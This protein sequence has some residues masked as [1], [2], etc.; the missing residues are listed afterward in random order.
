MRFSQP[1]LNRIV[2]MI[3]KNWKANNVVIFKAD[4][5]AVVESAMKAL[6]KELQ[7]EADL[8]KEVQKMLDNLEK[9]NSGE[10]QR[11]KMAGLLKQK[12]AKEKKVVL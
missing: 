7:K 6:N 8:D 12:L 2:E 10:F 1:Q 3:L 5:K 9:S 11:G 4:E